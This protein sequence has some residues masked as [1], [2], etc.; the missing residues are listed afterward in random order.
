MSYGM[1]VEGNDVGGNFIVTDT[2]LGLV[3]L[4]VVDSG[5][6]DHTITLD[7]ALQPTDLL[8]VKSPQPGGQDAVNGYGQQV[9][10]E[11]R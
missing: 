4:Q 8:F 3:N 1:K 5:T 6:N 2:D 7:T 11:Y 9:Y 10:S